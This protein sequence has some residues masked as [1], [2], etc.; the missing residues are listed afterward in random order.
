MAELHACGV[1][2]K[3]QDCKTA[4][5]LKEYLTNPE[6]GGDITVDFLKITPGE[7]CCIHCGKSYYYDTKDVVDF[8]ESGSIPQSHTP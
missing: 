2:C 5:I 6:G 1:I 4:I 7:L 8:G 3:N